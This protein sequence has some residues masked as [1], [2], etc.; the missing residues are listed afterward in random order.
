MHRSPDQW[1]VFSFLVRE[2]V[3]CVLRWLALQYQPAVVEGG[4]GR[5]T[6]RLVQICREAVFPRGAENSRALR[7]QG[8][9]KRS[10]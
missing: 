3:K 6:S 9:P 8:N 4:K 2:V 7:P 10:F 1:F 5:A